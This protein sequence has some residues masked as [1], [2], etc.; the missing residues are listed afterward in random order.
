M[1]I[2][3]GSGDNQTFLNQP[4]LDSARS[5]RQ[6]PGTAGK[7]LL[8][9]GRVRVHGGT[10]CPLHH[11]HPCGYRRDA[12]VLRSRH[13]PLLPRRHTVHVLRGQRQLQE[14][15]QEQGQAFCQVNR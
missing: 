9:L 11:L 4:F 8:V 7:G 13:I 5:A 6:G 1:T 12:H 10:D 2:F 3:W 14:A 15:Q